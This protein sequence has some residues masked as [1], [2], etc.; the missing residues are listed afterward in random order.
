MGWLNV[1]LEKCVEPAAE[2]IKNFSCDEWNKFKIDFNLAFTKYVENAYEKY[3]KI[4]TILYR[5]EPQNIYDFFESPLVSFRHGQINTEDVNNILDISHFIIIQGIGGI[6]KSILM[7]H[8]FIN[9]LKKKDLIP[10]FFELKDINSTVNWDIDEIIQTKL[11]RLG[12]KLD[13]KYLDY[14]MQGGCFLFLLDGYDEIE[15]EKKPEFFK[16]L[17]C[18]CDKYSKNYYIVSSRPYS[19]F[20]EFQRFTVLDVCAF[21]KEQTLSLVRKIDY[22]KEIKEKFL[23]ALDKRL[24]ERHKSFASNPLLLNIML[25]TFDNYAE[26]PEKLHI[27][28]ACAFD[29]MWSRHDATKGGFHREWKSRLPLDIFKQIFAEFCITTYSKAKLEFTY[30]ELEKC[31]SEILKRHNLENVHA[32]CYIDDLMNALCIIYKDGIMYRFTHRSFQEYFTA[33]F[34]NDLTDEQMEKLGQKLV[35]NDIHRAMFDSVFVMLY[36]M[37]KARFEKNILLPLISQCENER[38]SQEKYTYYLN[39][40]YTKVWFRFDCESDSH[41]DH[42]SGMSLGINKAVFIERFVGY[43]HRKVQKNP[44]IEKKLINHFKNKKEPLMIR[45]GFGR[46]KRKYKQL[47]LTVEEIQRDQYAYELLKKTWMGKHIENIAS[48]YEFLL[49]KQKKDTLDFSRLLE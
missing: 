4:K 45:T 12:Y 46:D 5:S 31:L 25:L 32:R 16:A 2:K 1:L 33:Y 40:V 3:S 35:Q 44:D 22:E 28:Y 42:I 48:F 27:F 19:E 43:Y 26:V 7:K 21:T 37:N 9:E 49:E 36:D 8:L 18:L 10:I 24:Y 23:F 39:Q 6:G 38:G 14:A 11:E 17:E 47:I 13:K 29:T 41:E 34:L 30:D 15:S 20:V